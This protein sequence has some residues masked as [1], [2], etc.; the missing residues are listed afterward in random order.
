M[1][2]DRATIEAAKV[3]ELREWLGLGPAAAAKLLGVDRATLWRWEDPKKVGCAQPPLSLVAVQE[4]HTRGVVL[5]PAPADDE[6]DANHWAWWSA[7]FSALAGETA[8]VELEDPGDMRDLEPHDPPPPPDAAAVLA[9]VRDLLE[10][11]PRYR[12]RLPIFVLREHLAALLTRSEL[13]MRL[14]ALSRSGELRLSTL[15]ETHLYTREQISAGIPT[16]V[17]GPYFFLIPEES[18]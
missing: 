4:A 11:Q 15:Q 2:K 7:L 8:G 17:G 6:Q 13:D 3:R 12:G 1:A 10:R 5:S 14:S 18:R 16:P 9:V